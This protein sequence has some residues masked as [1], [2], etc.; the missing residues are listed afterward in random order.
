MIEWYKT[1][2]EMVADDPEEFYS[3]F[4]DAEMKKISSDYRMEPCPMCGHS[5]CCT[6]TEIGVKCFSCDWKML[7]SRRSA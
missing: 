4:Y 7:F 5:G 2:N 6:V 1:I 3:S